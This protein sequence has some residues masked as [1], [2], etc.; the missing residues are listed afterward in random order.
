[1]ALPTEPG[2]PAIVV[3]PYP[4]TVSV[5]GGVLVALCEPEVTVHLYSSPDIAAVVLFTTRVA[6]SEPENVELSDTASHVDVPM[7]SR[8]QL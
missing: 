2:Q 4:L 3:T 5:A 6:V 8:C 1:L 7:G